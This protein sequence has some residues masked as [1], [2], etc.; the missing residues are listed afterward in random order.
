MTKHLLPLAILGFLATSCSSTRYGDPNQVETVNIDY[1]LSDLQALA[2]G[3]ADSLVQSPNLT[4]YEPHETGDP[5]IVVYFGGVENRTSEHI[6]TKGISSS[7]QSKLHNSGKFRVVANEQGQSEIG[8]Q[9]RFQQDSGRVANET[10]KAFGAQLGA[11]TILYGKLFGY[12]KS[13]G[14]TLENLGTKTEN[15]D[16]QFILEL[17]D[18]TTGELLWTDEE[19][20]RKTKKTGLFGG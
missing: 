10:A 17:V 3:M 20:V 9:V 5:R 4:Y 18:I 16:Y 19:L 6:D 2:G 12:D 11:D 1:G 15:V 14:R 8:D 13:S 7:I